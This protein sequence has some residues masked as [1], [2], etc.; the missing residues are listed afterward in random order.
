MRFLFGLI[1]NPPSSA[2]KTDFPRFYEDMVGLDL[3]R[4]GGGRAATAA[5]PPAPSTCA[6][7]SSWARS[8]ESVCGYLIVGRPELT[9][10]LADRLVDTILQGWS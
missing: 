3:P 5:S 8:G 4:G 1:H 2:P 6:C 9:T 7:W 10:D